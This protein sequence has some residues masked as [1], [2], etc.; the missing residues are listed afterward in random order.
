MDVDTPGGL[1][2]GFSLYPRSAIN[3]TNH[4]GAWKG[5]TDRKS[6]QFVKEHNERDCRMAA[7][8]QQ[9]C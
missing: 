9:K 8:P 1:E 5:G 4:F 6:G 3:L 2:N 7:L